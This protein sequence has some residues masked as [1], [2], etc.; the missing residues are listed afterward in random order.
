[1]DG[2]IK[3][4]RKLLESEIMQKPALFL[5]V[6]VWLIL[7]AQHEDY[8]GL[9]RGQG[10]TSIPDIIEAMKYKVGYR[11][12]RPTKKEIFG[13]IDWLRNPHEGNHEGD[14]IVT[15][16]VTNGFTYNI[17]KYEYYQD[18]EAHEGNNEGLTKVQRRSNKG[19]NLYNKNDKNV[20]NIEED[21]RA[22]EEGKIFEY[23]KQ[24]YGLIV[25][26]QTDLIGSYLD[27]GLS[28]ELIIKIL[29]GGLGKSDKW[30]W[31]KKVLQN[32]LEGNVKTVSDYEAKKLERSKPPPTTRAEKKQD[33][34]DRAKE[35][36]LKRLKEKGVITD[37]TS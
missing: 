29:E 5:K 28:A 17:V 10:K 3:L 15:T 23:Y 34:V 6:F 37:D 8:G 18:D 20:R 26:A 11:M 13:I 35:I 21:D 9:K 2:W 25:P 12:E 1:M 30:S 24:N 33:A 27:D 14:M 36:A 19:N 16:K 4:H 31:V 32:C 7:K 22:R